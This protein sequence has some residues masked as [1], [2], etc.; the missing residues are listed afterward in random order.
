M[1]KWLELSGVGGIAG[2]GESW[3]QQPQGPGRGG[4]VTELCPPPLAREVEGFAKG[5]QGLSLRRLPCGSG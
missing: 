3:V 1:V 2:G 4:A 5:G